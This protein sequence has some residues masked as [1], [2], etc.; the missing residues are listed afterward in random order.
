[1]LMQLPW[2]SSRS[3]LMN[4]EMFLAVQYMFA[5]IS[6]YC[7]YNNIHKINRFTVKMHAKISR[8]LVINEHFEYYQTVVQIAQ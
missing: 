5:F 8:N 4:V 7:F 2:I 1:M 6:A 3:R